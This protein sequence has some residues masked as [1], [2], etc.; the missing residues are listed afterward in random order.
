VSREEWHGFLKLS[1]ERDGG[2]HLLWALLA[3]TSKA[4]EAIA[5]ERASCREA[6]AVA[7]AKAT[8]D[9]VQAK[10]TADAEALVP[11]RDAAVAHVEGDGCNG[12]TDGD[13]NQLDCCHIRTYNPR[14]YWR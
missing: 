6:A 3:S 11:V 8:E 12:K 4:L 10:A 9:A 14:F 7:A 13:R 1:R 5:A 2:D